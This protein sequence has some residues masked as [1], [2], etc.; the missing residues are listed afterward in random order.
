MSAATSRDVS[1]LIAPTV[2]VETALDAGKVWREKLQGQ[3]LYLT[4]DTTVDDALD[5]AQAVVEMSLSEWLVNPGHY[6]LGA[7]AREPPAAE[8]GK[9][10]LTLLTHELC[11][12][13][14]LGGLGL[15]SRSRQPYVAFYLLAD[16]AEIRRQV[17]ALREMLVASQRVHWRDLP[18]PMRTVPRKAWRN[19]IIGHGEW[20][21]LGWQ[22]E[23]GALNA[24]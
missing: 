24:W 18:D 13:S 16:E 15:L 4:M 5:A 19:T 23:D 1:R 6:L 3:W 21:G 22:S 2:D 14:R 12:R 17:D 9:P 11:S 20:L 7:A 10:A 8:I